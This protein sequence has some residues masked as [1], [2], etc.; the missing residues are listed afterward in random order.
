MIEI[1]NYNYNCLIMS[2]RN[3]RIVENQPELHR[4]KQLPNKRAQWR[5][6]GKKRRGAAIRSAG[7]IFSER[8]KIL[9]RVFFWLKKHF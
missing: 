7:K 9:K 1:I 5:L 4:S 2:I 6:A 3:F 8:G